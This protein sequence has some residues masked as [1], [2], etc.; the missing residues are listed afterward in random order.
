MATKEEILLVHSDQFYE[1]MECTKTLSGED[2]AKLGGALRSIDY[3]NVWKFPLIKKD[4]CFSI[5]MS[6]IMHY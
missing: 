6:L 3:N 4:L 1:K 5:R 2:L